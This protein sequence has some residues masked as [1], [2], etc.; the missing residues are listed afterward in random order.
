MDHIEHLEIPVSTAAEFMVHGQATARDISYLVTVTALA[1]MDSPIDQ[2]G[3]T[4][5][6]SDNGLR[7]LLGRIRRSR[8]EVEE[9]RFDRL[10]ELTV[11]VPQEY[12]PVRAAN[13][14]YQRLSTGQITP[15]RSTGKSGK[16]MWEVPPEL[17]DAFRS[18]GEETVQ[19]P[20]RLLQ[21]AQSRYTVIGMLRILAWL[22]GDVDRRW[23]HKRGADRLTLRIPIAEFYETMGLPELIKPS[24]VVTDVAQVLAEEISELTDYAVEATGRMIQ[25]KTSRRGRLRDVEIFI[26]SPAPAVGHGWKAPDRPSKSTRKVVQPAPAD[27]SNVASIRPAARQTMWGRPMPG[28]A[29]PVA[30]ADDDLP[31]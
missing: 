21:F 1:A 15:I 27:T 7:Q 16:L 23:V 29:M 11:T 28:E 5:R 26:A 25:T 18:E 9:A 22:A 8:M 17:V 12:D 19:L 30:T 6:L 13:V 24:R 2:A 10:A 31:F 14:P 4:Y 20:M 3:L